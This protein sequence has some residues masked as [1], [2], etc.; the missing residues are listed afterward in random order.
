MRLSARTLVLAALALVALPAAALAQL[1]FSYVVPPPPGA[2]IKTPQSEIRAN[3]PGPGQPRGPH[4]WW[5]MANTS[6]AMTV[7]LAIATPDGVRATIFNSADVPV[8][9]IAPIFGS[10]NSSGNEVRSSAT[11]ATTP[12]AQY[13]VQVEASQVPSPGLCAC[14]IYF[15][16][17]GGAVEAGMATPTAFNMR[18]VPGPPEGDHSGSSVNWRLNVGPGESLDLQFNPT[19]GGST[20]PNLRVVIIDAADHVRLDERVSPP[21]VSGLPRQI[22]IPDAGNTPGAWIMAVWGDEGPFPDGPYRILRTSGADRA[23]Y[24][25][26]DTF[27]VGAIDVSVVQGAAPSTTLYTGPVDVLVTSIGGFSE[28][29]T[30][31]GG[32]VTDD[33]DSVGARR[34]HVTAPAGWTATPA[35]GDLIVTYGETAFVTLRLQDLT[36]P[37]L[38]LPEDITVS[39]TSA[40][41]AAVSF[42]VSATDIDVVEVSSPVTC[43]SASG[44]T[45][46]I[47]QT[48][49]TCTATDTHGN[50][51]TG[52]FRV[53]VVNVAVC[54]AARASIASIWAPNHKLVDINVLGVSTL[55]GAAAGITITGIFQD[56]ATN[57]EGDGDTAID[58]FG[59]GTSTA[60]VRAERSGTG[61]GRV[62]HIAFSA[63]VAGGSS[64]TGVVTVEVPHSNGRGPAVDG[65]ALFDST[66]ASGINSAAAS[67]I[68][69]LRRL[70]QL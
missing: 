70:S 31:T 23:A 50:T 62:Y 15:L 69:A 39:A 8:G 17:L 34:W 22:H 12:G 16:E 54:S 13:R 24:V 28:T 9:S 41:G 19:G 21:A 2:R 61:D 25:A 49:V 64:C 67:P 65:G 3:P 37:T 33:D 27:G 35:D 30:I 63:T 4:N 18:A 47:G 1:P 58:G 42:A 57:A 11:F 56:E 40:S 66:V 10:F 68:V 6:G 53:N 52:T 59:V 36:A 38:N 26:W 32:R 20:A 7:T 29:R 60:Q 51:T 45:F 5:V 55:S 48:T 44:S 46:A 14:P 43:S